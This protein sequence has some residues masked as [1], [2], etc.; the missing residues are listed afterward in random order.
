[1]SSALTIAPETTSLTLVTSKPAS[2]SAAHRIALAIVWLTVASGFFVFS[3]PAPFD[4]LTMGLF[5]LLPVLGLFDAKR[6]VVAGFALWMVV[7]TATIV[8]CVLAR[9]YGE[10]TKHSFISFYLYGACFLFAGFVAK[11]PYAHARLIL[12]AYFVA[13]ICAA[14]L[15]VA[16]YLD[17]FPGAFELLTR[18]GRA[19]GTFKDPNVFGPFLIPGLLMALQQFLVRPL[20]RGIFPALAAGIITLA[21]LFS[22]SRGAWAATAI[23]LA[24]YC[25]VYLHS[26]DRDIQRIKLAGLILLG[27]AVLGLVLAV[28]MQSDAVAQLLSER[29]ALTQPYDEGPDGRFG[30]QK[31]AFDLILEN[32]LGIGAQAFTLFHHHEEAHNVYLSIA[33]NAGWLGGLLYLLICVGTLYLGFEHA[34]KRT[35]TQHLFVIAF[36]AL[37]GTMIEGY[38]IDTDHWRH[39]YLLLGV[40]WGLMASDRKIERKA[41]IVR[42]VRPVLMRRVLIVPPSARGNR[43][44]RRLPQRLPSMTVPQLSYSYPRRKRS[45]ARPGR[46][47]S[48]TG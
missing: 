47:V 5:I 30:G 36:A 8:A 45:P 26:A 31:K 2:K 35:K 23:A 19:A 15:G 16:G 48:R 18:Y 42:D 11:S 28:A 46:I 41:R 3:E 1:M 12:N 37:A 13:S 43:I 24:I 27:T 10:A 34:L 17:L 40:V 14:I 33:M 32:P 44:V 4:A 22:F 21:I 39:F 38:L 7:A 9:D 29:A 20:H 6:G 25:F